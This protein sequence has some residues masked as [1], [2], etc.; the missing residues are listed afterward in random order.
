[1]SRIGKQPITIPEG[2]TLN[3]AD[4]VVTVKGPKGELH[5]IVHP[6]ISIVEKDGIAT[7]SV[8]HPTIKKERSMWGT[9]NSLIANMVTGVTEGFERKLEI[10]GVGY[11]WQVSG[12]KLTVKAGYSRPVIVQLPEGITATVEDNVLTI[13][14][15]SKHTVGETAA[16][17]R[18]IRLTEPYKG[19]GIKYDDEHVRRKSGKQAAGGD[20]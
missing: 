17:I 15:N 4:G 20:A 19:T 3:V 7:V 2:V 16:S 11:G 6:F 9:F 10:N 12:Q 8:E 13:S 18:K 14:G 5:E 1:M